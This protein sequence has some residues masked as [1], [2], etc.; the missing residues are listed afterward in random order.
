MSELAAMWSI[1]YLKS[2][3]KL[4]SDLRSSGIL[5]SAEWLHDN[6]SLQLQRSGSPKNFF[7]DILI[8]STLLTS[9]KGADLIHTLPEVR[10]LA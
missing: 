8:N 1:N 6:V 2:L 4:R 7:L 3:I 10:N 9:Q 5:R